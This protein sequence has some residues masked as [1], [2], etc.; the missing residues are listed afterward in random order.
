M[1][2]C[3]WACTCVCVWGVNNCVDKS[4]FDLKI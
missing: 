4:E 3:V 2:A 1:C